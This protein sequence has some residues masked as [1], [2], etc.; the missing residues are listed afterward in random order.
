MTS[1]ANLR[2]DDLV[3]GP[4]ARLYD[5]IS[6]DPGIHFSA[7]LQATH[8]GAGHLQYHLWVLERG[9]VIV[10][11]K[12]GRFKRFFATAQAQETDRRAILVERDDRLRRLGDLL[13]APA[14]PSITQLA[15]FLGISH[16]AVA[17]HV[18]RLDHLRQPDSAFSRPRTRSPSSEQAPVGRVTEPLRPAQATSA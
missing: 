8:W 14:R 1:G 10:A 18:R 13:R 15:R 4:R 17:Y 9:G 16:Q 11:R 12:C 7:L 5:L 2:P 3:T 6:N